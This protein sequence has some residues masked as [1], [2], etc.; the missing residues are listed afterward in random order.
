MRC[1]YCGGI[2]TDQANYCTR[3][4][5]GLSSASQTPSAPQTTRT[6]P[7]P[8]TSQTS[9]RLQP[10]PASGP[11]GAAAPGPSG[12][13]RRQGG[14]GSFALSQPASAAAM[15]RGPL[16]TS[17]PSPP[18]PPP[19]P[20][21]FPPRTLAQL[22]ALQPGA[23]DYTLLGS[24]L[25]PGRK[26]LVEIQ[27]PSCAPWQQ[28][29]TLYRALG[30][31]DEERFD[32]IVVR[33]FCEQTEARSSFDNGE[34]IFDRQARLGGQVIRRY[35]IATHHGF[36]VDSVRIVLTEEQTTG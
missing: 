35:L 16:A 7:S 14:P 26:K 27:Y 18:P 25:L 30:D 4:G 3:C 15:Q 8:Q 9:Q 6:Q 28:V 11:P 33:G 19:P 32:T 13:R 10:A 12:G 1:P 34:L 29:A 20:A 22:Q 31:H 36:E 21:P 23:L 5:R 2:N 17:P 24:S